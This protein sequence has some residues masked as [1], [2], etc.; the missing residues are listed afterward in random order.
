MASVIAA[1]FLPSKSG[2]HF[3]NDFPK[4]PVRTIPIPHVG[5]IPIGDA[6]GGLCGGTVFTARAVF[7][8]GLTPPPG[9]A[10]HSP[11]TKLF[12]YLVDR[13]IDSFDLPWGVARYF[14]W[15]Q[16]PDEDHF[17]FR[18]AARRTWQ[19]EWPSL[20]ADL[21]AGHPAPLGLVTVRSLNPAA[22]KENH[23]V[24]AY[25]YDL[26]DG[27]GTLTLRVYDPNLPNDDSVRLTLTGGSGE[28]LPT[29]SYSGGMAVRAFFRTPYRPRTDI[30]G[31]LGR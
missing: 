4:V 28:G 14:E 23:H 5:E 11:R 26:A 1:G 17:F 27:G 6:S 2:F 21:D 19:D 31:I 22:L 29:V 30:Q 13:L 10:P 18:G 7:E 3:A 16:L 8:Q 15:M 25:A 24:L 9:E 12:N 20:R